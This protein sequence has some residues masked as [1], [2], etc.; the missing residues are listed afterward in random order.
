MVR[1]EGKELE[2]ERRLWKELPNKDGKEELEEERAVWKKFG[3]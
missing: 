2:E 1:K 3:M